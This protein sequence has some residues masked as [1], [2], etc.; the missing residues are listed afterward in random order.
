MRRQ[1]RKKS[2][3]ERNVV[4]KELYKRIQ[5]A[6]IPPSL[7][8]FEEL[9]I[10]SLYLP[11][12]KRGGDLFDIIKKSENVIAFYI[13]DISR[14]GIDS[15]LISA[16]LKISFSN[17]IRKAAKPGE[18][19]RKINIDMREILGDFYFTAFTGFLDLHDNRLIYC[20]AGHPYPA[21]YRK[22]NGSVDF[23]EKGGP[24][25]GLIDNEVFENSTTHLYP[26]DWLM[27]YTNGL[28]QL[29]EGQKKEIDLSEI[30]RLLMEFKADT[31]R[32]I[33][34]KIEE[35][36]DYKHSN[37]SFSDDI[38]MLSVEILSQSRRDR[39]KEV[40]GFRKEDPVYLQ[41]LSYYEEMDRTIGAVLKDMDNA[42]YC[43]DM[44]RQMKLTL[45]ELCANAIGHGNR[46]DHN[47]KVTLGHI[48]SKNVTSVAIMDEGDGYDPEK[49]PDPT[50][51]QNLIKDSGR[52]LFIVKSYVDEIHHN[53]KANRILIRKY[54]N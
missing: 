24:F 1:D 2:G 34:K 21:I 54:R 18:V 52:G 6:L 5:H 7:P 35:R 15:T 3:K 27:L 13:L 14:R 51:P 38:T 29:L 50:T 40:L 36:V 44:I 17:H 8:E 23:L 42:G 45:T 9:E 37:D 47:K 32:G 46:E 4:E 33:L 28:H 16:F 20:N 43:D 31:A 11:C 41:Y 25:I 12:R 39:T 53:S 19:L 48:V 22:K 49:V 10:S 26:G 30:E